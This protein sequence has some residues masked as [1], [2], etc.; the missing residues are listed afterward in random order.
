MLAGLWELPGIEYKL[1]TEELRKHLTDL[2][3]VPEEINK[4][5]DAKHIFSHVEWNMSGYHVHLRE[6]PQEYSKENAIVW[7][8]TT[9]LINTY[10]I[11]N[12]FKSYTKDIKQKKK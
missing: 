7:A 8:D 1:N 4:L 3:I 12:A 9:D 10:S 2:R 11:P 6:L 5:N